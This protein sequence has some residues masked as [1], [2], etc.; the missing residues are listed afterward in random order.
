MPPRDLS[1]SSRVLVLRWANQSYNAAVFYANKSVSSPM[2][3]SQIFAA[4]CAAVT[5]ALTVGLGARS[6]GPPARLSFYNTEFYLI[7]PL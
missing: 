7:L 6:I 1:N 5:A 4:Y 2:P 3:N